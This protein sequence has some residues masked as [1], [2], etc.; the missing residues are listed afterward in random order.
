MIRSTNDEKKFITN[1]LFIIFSF[2]VKSQVRVNTSNPQ[3]IFNVDRLKNYP[4]TGI[5]TAAQAQDD[6]GRYR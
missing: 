2:R 6:L 3:G 4:S 1:R 5:P